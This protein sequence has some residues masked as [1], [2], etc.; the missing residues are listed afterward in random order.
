MS[1]DTAAK[2]AAIVEKGEYVIGIAVILA[3]L[4]VSTTVYISI[5]GLQD[6]VSKLKLDVTV[7][8][9][10]AQP[11]AQ[12]QAAQQPA[13]QQQA[14][15]AAPAA[16]TPADTSSFAKTDPGIGPADAKV[17]VIAFADYQCPYCGIT[18]G[19]QLGSQYDSIFNVSGKIIAQ[20]AQTGKI[21]FV[22]HAMAFLGQ[23]SIDAANAA[24]CAR[25]VGGDA[26]YFKMHDELFSKQNQEN[27]G[28]FSID[29]LK[30]YAA[31]AGFGTQLDSCITSGKYDTQVTQSTSQA[32]AAGIQGTPG[33]MVNGVQSNPDYTTLKAAIDKAIAG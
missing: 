1:K 29:N 14:A 30:K 7:P 9:A 26:A 22:Y 33:F 19:R 28:T 18:A 2:S 20:Y 21:R 10:A 25:E 6:T 12:Q 27:D 15:A 23:G 32:N 17:T 4:L 8:A 11:A 3:A 5:S 24:F 13:A 31:E 16:G